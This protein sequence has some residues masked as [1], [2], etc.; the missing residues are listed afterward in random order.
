MNVF[1]RLRGDAVLSTTRVLEGVVVWSALMR[2]P[3]SLAYDR[4]FFVMHVPSQSHRQPD[5]RLTWQQ[6]ARDSEP[7]HI[8]SCVASHLVE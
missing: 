4:I 6:V 2:A 5:F 3:A 1:R 8:R 7:E